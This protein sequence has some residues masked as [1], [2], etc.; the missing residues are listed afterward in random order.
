MCVYSDF[1][2][3]KSGVYYHKSGGISGYHPVMILGYGF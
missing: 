1:F 3:Y 2:S